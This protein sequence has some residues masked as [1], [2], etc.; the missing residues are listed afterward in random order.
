MLKCKAEF[1]WRDEASS[2][3]LAKKMSTEGAKYS[4]ENEME[5]V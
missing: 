2:E 3:E 1:I 4:P 5:V